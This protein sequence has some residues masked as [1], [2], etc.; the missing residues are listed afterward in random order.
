LQFFGWETNSSLSGEFRIDSLPATEN[1]RIEDRRKR[2]RIGR[3]LKFEDYKEQQKQARD[4]SG[5]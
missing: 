4:S 5:K 3:K 2:L 1:A